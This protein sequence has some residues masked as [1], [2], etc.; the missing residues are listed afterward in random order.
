MCDSTATAVCFGPDELLLSPPTAR[1]TFLL[2][3]TPQLITSAIIDSP[4]SNY[5]LPQLYSAIYSSKLTYTDNIYDTLLTLSRHKWSRSCFLM[6]QTTH[7]S[8]Q[9]LSTP[10]VSVCK[11]LNTLPTHPRASWQAEPCVPYV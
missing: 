9:I 5:L 4:H 3:N 11:A 6:R 1:A 8:L 7:S 2:F 10:T